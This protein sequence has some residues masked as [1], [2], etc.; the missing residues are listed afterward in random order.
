MPDGKGNVRDGEMPGG[1]VAQ[2]VVVVGSECW[3][4][5]R[6]LG[7]LPLEVFD[8]SPWLKTSLAQLAGLFLCNVASKISLQQLARIE[9]TGVVLMSVHHGNIV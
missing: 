4:E 9:S 3:G 1:E 6:A 7:E 5:G 2:E 8:P